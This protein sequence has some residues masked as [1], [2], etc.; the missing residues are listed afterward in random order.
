MLA[1]FL[2]SLL[3][4]KRVL[5]N[6]VLDWVKVGFR[7]AQE[8]LLQGKDEVDAFR[9]V[10]QVER[11]L[12]SD[13]ALLKGLLPNEKEIT[14]EIVWLIH[15]NLCG[16][17]KVQLNKH[18]REACIDSLNIIFRTEK[19]LVEPITSVVALGLADN[20]S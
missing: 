3:Q 12:E 5:I 9:K 15:A 6:K 14:E 18:I 1:G 8:A 17:K 19:T 13:L 11:Y 16:E 2:A 4:E 10:A 7:Q 20:W